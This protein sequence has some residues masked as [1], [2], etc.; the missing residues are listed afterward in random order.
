MECGI[1]KGSPRVGL[2][3]AGG[4]VHQCRRSWWGSSCTT[5]MNRVKLVNSFLPDFKISK[6]SFF[7]DNHFPYL[8]ICFPEKPTKKR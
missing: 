8:L 5:A 4:F 7:P 6:K 2:L 3:R 1:I